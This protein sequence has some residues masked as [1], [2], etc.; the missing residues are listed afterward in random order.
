MALGI[1]GLLAILVLSLL[2]LSSGLEMRA[3][4]QHLS[5]KSTG[6]LNTTMIAQSFR[7]TRNN[8]SRIDLEVASIATLPRSAEFSL[9]EGDG[10]GGRLVYRNTL[11]NASFAANP[12]LE[13]QFPP[14]ASSNGVTYT[15]VLTTSGVP[16]NRF[17]GLRYN[18]FDALS[19]G[20]MYTDDGAQ[21]GDLDITTYYHYGLQDALS[22]AGSTL[23][24]GLLP[25]LS[26]AFLLVLPGLALLVWLPGS[27][28]IGQRIL[29]APGV[30]LLAL[31]L[32]YLVTRAVSLPMSGGALWLLLGLCLVLVVVAV[33]R[34]GQPLRVRMLD[35]ASIAFWSL[36]IVVFA[37]TIYSRMLPLHDL[38]AGLGLDAYHHT[39]IAQMFVEH[40]GVPAN[41]EPYAPLASFTYHFGFHAL[42]ASIAWLTGQTSPT[43]MLRLMPV[44]GQVATGLPALTLTLFGWKVF[45][46]RW[47]GLLAGALA[48]LVSIFPAYYVNW[49]RYTQGLG[50]ALLP[51]AIILFLEVVQRPVRAVPAAV[52]QGRLVP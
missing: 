5:D 9:L 26:W 39:L 20:K 4:E 46:N 10:P 43:D 38:Q 47:A 48:G 2:S 13:F 29:A 36:L 12:F 31:P 7:S 8:L 24:Q 30:S 14:I 35:A 51:V 33:V 50:L 52:N 16:L 42:A 44:A 28:T 17:V 41:Y 34:G 49:S 23:T 6:D 21:R 11:D 32:I 25:V 22:D 40:G 3:F 18:S 37:L 15:L 45:G 27:L 19:S 1:V